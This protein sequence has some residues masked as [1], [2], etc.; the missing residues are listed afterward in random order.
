MM[1][2]TQANAQIDHRLS[3]ETPIMAVPAADENQQGAVLVV[4]LAPARMERLFRSAG[5]V[6]IHN[7]PLSDGST[8]DL[9][10]Q[11]F[12][13]LTPDAQVVLGSATGDIPIEAPDVKL[14]HGTVVGQPDSLVFLSFAPSATR[15]LIQTKGTTFVLSAGQVE[16]GSPLVIADL[17][18]FPEPPEFAKGWECHTDA[19]FM[20][21][22]GIELTDGDGQAGPR[23]NPCRIAR[24][25][26]DSDYEFTAWKFGGD[27]EASGAYALTLFGA[28]NE[29]YTRELNVRLIVPFV[30]V[31]DADVDPYHDSGGSL[32]DEFRNEW[33]ANMTGIGRE[34]G[35]MLSGDYGGGV[36][37]VS[38]VCS[39]SYGYGL[40]G[41]SGSFPYPLVDHNSGN[42]DLY[43][44]SHEMGHNFGTLHT[45]DGYDPPLDGCGLGD[46]S[47]AW[48][49]TIM[50]YCHLCS[51]GMNNIVLH[52]HPVVHDKI[53]TYLDS[54]CDILGENQAYAYD[55]NATALRNTVLSVD[56]LANDATVNCTTVG[57]FSVQS[58]TDMGGS[59]T[60]SSG[61]GSEGRD[62]LV[63]TPPVDFVGTDTFVYF[64][65]TGNGTITSANVFVD[66]LP[67]SDA[68]VPG[69]SR[70]GVTVD[71]YELTDAEQLPDFST[72]V[73]YGRDI[74][75]D[76]NIPS[77]NGYFA[78]SGRFEFVGAVFNG[79]VEVPSTDLYVFSLESDD[80]SR[81]FID[82]QLVLEN[83]GVHRMTEVAGR[84]ALEAGFHR[85]RIEYFE[86]TQAQGLIARIESPTMAKQV[87]PAS[88]WRTDACV[89]DWVSDGSINTI[90]F[91][92]F[93]GDWTATDPSTD[94][95]GNGTI[96]T[97]DV[98]AYINAW[99]AGC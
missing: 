48:G 62:E 65:Q 37:W 19:S 55:D 9:D 70:P 18:A 78:T 54:A 53:S 96:N 84:I 63:Y 31:W 69:T 13:M 20:N 95:D 30:R 3:L 72:L 8:I 99:V 14:Y 58:Q 85:A 52:F 97:A 23:S 32:L 45:H 12:S 2:S 11:R 73:P 66:V 51:G 26:I 77:S 82:D 88:L 94:L 46:C 68:V 76:I 39:K 43:V 42:W 4:E 7:F 1:V 33:N 15:G 90:D 75:P 10:V 24:I 49:G 44:V 71:Y 35:H 17:A 83:D 60:I 64:M 91:I 87:I 47:H 80:G 5:P 74:L 86:K 22:L 67:V 57:I 38:V 21:P 92:S 6:T 16:S 98:V 27:I 59:V 56:V 29:I 50:S 25:A 36:A 40:S 61:T 41:V 89:A 28:I 34:L 93:L 81:L 79:L